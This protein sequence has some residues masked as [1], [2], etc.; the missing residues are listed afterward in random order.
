VLE[1]LLAAGF[2]GLL[3]LIW[4]RHG[5]PAVDARVFAHTPP[6]AGRHVSSGLST[7]ARYVTDLGQPIAWTVGTLVLAAALALARHSWFPFRLVVLPVGVEAVVVLT[8]KAAVGRVGPPGST[9]GQSGGYFPSGHTATALVCTGALAALLAAG[10][11]EW[12]RALRIAVFAWSVLMAAA[13]VY[14]GYH[15]LTDVVAS[16]LLGFLILRLACPGMWAPRR[17]GDDSP[18]KDDALRLREN[19]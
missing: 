11:P 15:W 13:L 8:L 14:V 7:I 4:T 6:A 19:A 10:R 5:P 12:A 18:P 3:V 16:L 17:S 2:V 1:V 9:G